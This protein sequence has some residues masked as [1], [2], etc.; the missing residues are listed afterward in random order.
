MSFEN[1][2]M[3]NLRSSVGCRDAA[4]RRGWGGSWGPGQAGNTDLELEEA[5]GGRGVSGS[6]LRAQVGTGTLWGLGPVH[7]EED[8]PLPQ[9]SSPL[10]GSGTRVLAAGARAGHLPVSPGD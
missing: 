8:L 9:V 1:L 7:P 6:S 2:A 5:L 4:H 10:S 3:L